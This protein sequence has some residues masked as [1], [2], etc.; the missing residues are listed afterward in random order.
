MLNALVV[1]VMVKKL[2]W[3]SS[4]FDKALFTHKRAEVVQIPTWTDNSLYSK[5]FTVTV[6]PGTAWLGRDTSCPFPGTLMGKKGVIVTTE[7]LSVPILF[8]VFL[9]LLHNQSEI[10]FYCR[11]PFPCLDW[12][13]FKNNP[14]PNNKCYGC[15]I[16]GCHTTAAWQGTERQMS[17]SEGPSWCSPAHTAH[18]TLLFWGGNAEKVLARRGRSCLSWSDRAVTYRL[19][20]ELVILERIFGVHATAQRFRGLLLVF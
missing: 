9:S 5:C 8:L 20:F 3:C 7:S 16:H 15:L 17:L 14:V 4:A 10:C 12:S 13:P 6:P 19:V 2:V 1:F 18:F 11:L